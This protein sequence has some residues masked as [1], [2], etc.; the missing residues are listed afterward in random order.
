[1]EA[2]VAA[3]VVAMAE[4]VDVAEIVEIAETAG[5]TRLPT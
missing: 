4:A 2:A 3:G 5:N 1:M